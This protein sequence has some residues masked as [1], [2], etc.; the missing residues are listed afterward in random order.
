MIDSLLASLNF[1]IT[2]IG[3]PCNDRQ[4]TDC[5]ENITDGDHGRSPRERSQRKSNLADCSEREV[6]RGLTRR[7]VPGESCYQKGILPLFTSLTVMLHAITDQPHAML[8]PNKPSSD[9]FHGLPDARLILF[10]SYVLLDS[11]L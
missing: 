11:N 4:T 3:A 2:I 1:P 6:C 9:T 7:K 8:P 10:A 5:H